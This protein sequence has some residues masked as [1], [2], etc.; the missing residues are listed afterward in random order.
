MKILAIRGKNLAS[1]EDEFVIDFN[2]EPL[3]S[4]GLFA[5]VGPTG[6][7]KSTILDTICLALYDKIPRFNSAESKTLDDNSGGLSLSDTRNVL[8]KGAIDGYAEVDFRAINGNIYRSKWAVRRSRNKIEGQLQASTME[9]YNLTTKEDVQGKKTE[10]KAEIEKLVGLEYNQFT[11]AVLLAQGEFENFIKAKESEK[12]ELLEK[13]TGTDIYSEISRRIYEAYT[14]AKADKDLL[15]KQMQSIDLMPEEQLIEIQHNKD[16]LNKDLVRINE[17][18][19]VLGK[20]E[21]WW[22]EEITLVNK[23]KNVEVSKAKSE[24]DLLQSQPQIDYLQ[25]IDRSQEIREDFLEAKRVSADSEQKMASHKEYQSVYDINVAKKKEV[26]EQFDKLILHKEDL[27]KRYQEAK[28][29]ID[30]AK[31]L[32]IQANNIKIQQDAVGTELEKL[33]KL[34]DSTKNRLE[35]LDKEQ[36]ELSTKLA[37][38]VTWFTEKNNLLPIIENQQS[39]LHY[40]DKYDEV[41]KALTEEDKMIVLAQ[42]SLQDKESQLQVESEEWKVLN[43]TQPSEV[44][45][46]RKSLVEGQVCPVCGSEEHP[47]AGEAGESVGL[48]QEELEKQ[49]TV[50]QD[51]IEKTSKLI[52]TNK[53][54]LI[55]YEVN[56]ENY[57]KILVEH[58]SLLNKYLPLA[59]PNWEILLTEAKSLEIK[60]KVNDIV[61]QWSDNLAIKEKSTNRIETIVV[62]LKEMDENIAQY[63]KQ[64]DEKKNN[65]ESI[66]NESKKINSERIDI[67]EGQPI[68]EIE[69]KY[70]ARIKD[71]EQN[72]SKV[73]VEKD[74]ID[75]AIASSE[76]ILKSLQSQL[77]SNSKDL[78]S[79]NQS[80]NNWLANQRDIS[81][82]LLAELTTRK[83]EWIAQERKFIEGLQNNKIVIDTTLKERKAD[84]QKHQENVNKPTDNKSKENVVAEIQEATQQRSETNTQ[85]LDIEVKIKNQIQNRDR[86]SKLEKDSKAKGELLSQ[87]EKLYVL[88]GSRTGDKFKKIAQGYTL[89]ILLEYAN[90][91]LQNLNKRFNLQKIPNSLILQVVDNDMFGEVRPVHSLSGGESFLI[92]LALALGLSSLSSNQMNIESL[93]IDEGFGSLDIDTLNVAMEALE[94]L[95]MQG[96]KIGIISHVDS[97]KE[98]IT[99]QIQVVKTANGGSS[100]IKIEG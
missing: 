49:K 17:L 24:Q 93:F 36:K 82:D 89:D 100:R 98:R 2:Q 20:Q 66:N 70:E 90:V 59:L 42:K 44:I 22:E 26:G 40:I 5:I 6:A 11:R 53:A 86:L 46:L 85:L 97:M 32:D 58:L 62:Q 34:N 80:I 56:N 64:I 50:L 94:N 38:L 83:V 96:R 47:Y 73:R 25:L 14:N 72:I 54:N 55:K 74:D 99:T 69:R 27:E 63:Q 7:G 81:K 39:I 1:L 4:S 18:L 61:K 88:L 41:N 23:I 19:G 13:L 48:K 51:K 79:L 84:W 95:Q 75:K 30:R 33:T 31:E 29:K 21:L 12:A 68:Q 35:V 92:S 28:P 76:A 60:S 9:L 10:L 65:L 91:H 3:L 71:L 15:D 16:Q 87:W 37:F 78:Q 77:E 52:E 8:H 67:F 45:L 57:Q 43:E